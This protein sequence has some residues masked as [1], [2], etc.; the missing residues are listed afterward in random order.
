MSREQTLVLPTVPQYQKRTSFATPQPLRLAFSFF[1][2]LILLLGVYMPV[3]ATNHK[4][5]AR[6]IPSAQISQAHPS[7]PVHLFLMPLSTTSIQL[8][9]HI[10][11]VTVN[12]EGDQP[13]LSIRSSYRL[14]NPGTESLTLP[15]QI[16]PTEAQISRPR[17][18]DIS[19]TVDGQPLPLQTTEDQSLNTQVTMGADSRR[20]L[21]LS[22]QIRL[23]ESELPSFTYP[24][25]PLTIWAGAT[26]SWRVTLTLPGEQTRLLPAESWV[27]TAPEGWTYNGTQLQWLSEGDLPAQPITLQFIHPRLWR[28]L[29][30]TRL[31][32]TGQPSIDQF[33]SL[34]DLYNQLY[35][36]P[37][38][39]EGG[40]QR[41][42][43]QALAAY[44]DG[45]A[46]GQ[47]IGT[48]AAALGPLHRALTALYRS[49]SVKADG[50]IDFAYV[51][52]MVAEAQK[53]VTA[54]AQS[55]GQ[56]SE[57]AQWLVEGLKLQLRHA[58]QIEDWQSSFTILDQM[59]KL[60]ADLV[61]ANWL[62]SE[63]QLVQ[64][65]QALTLIEQNNEEAAIALAGADIVDES[66]LPRPENRILF[67]SWQVTLTVQPESTHIQ[68]VAWP[69]QGREEVA[70][71]TFEQLIQTWQSAGA[72]GLQT[73]TR[74]D[75]AIVIALNEN[76]F[77]KRIE[78]SQL[79]PP[80][81]DWA[82][83][84]NL[85]VSIE[86][87]QYRRDR[88]IWQEVEMSQRIDLRPVADQWRGIAAQLERQA[89]Q[90]PNV[91]VLSQAPTI[92]ATQAEMREQLRRIYLRQEAQAWHHAVQSSTMRVQ[93]VADTSAEDRSNSN[94]RVWILQMTD[95]PQTLNF[96]TEVLSSARLLLA[97]IS[98]LILILALA[99]VL[100]LLL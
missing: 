40:R 47:Q 55:G 45:I 31:A 50:T 83:L 3:G 53:A 96:H 18:T 11:D 6:A 97:I 10:V 22:Y 23:V 25:Q 1:L 15:L 99:G 88:L 70:R 5:H 79:I 90:V 36:S 44:A 16:A 34:G 74:E 56:S 89:E 17:P 19:L 86:P 64:L 27:N 33:L 80:V 68:L 32:I 35:R 38:V 26:E 13:I 37:Q 48:E 54:L 62:A 73:T 14:H 81:A 84:R 24:T 60:P 58:Q 77:E 43:A 82:L 46:Y 29:T 41:F 12:L 57:V 87:S 100:W 52:L 69:Y 72:S 93:M 94:H 91:P 75:G 61:D 7:D 59:S 63:R 92:D 51:D 67:A 30:T 21:V 9:T 39:S 76:T 65:Q 85:L 98:L 28:D 71:Q 2:L 4:R 8:L 49:R 42:Y 66:L 20:M 78:L 95:V